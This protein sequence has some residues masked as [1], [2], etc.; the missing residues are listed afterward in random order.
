ML[1]LMDLDMPV[2]DGFESARRMRRLETE[3]GWQP[4]VILA[5]SAHVMPEY[6]ERIKEVG[7]DGQLI[8]PLTLSALQAALHQYLIP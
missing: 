3:N 7:M 2:M 6:A 4:A 1:V 8:K 5:L